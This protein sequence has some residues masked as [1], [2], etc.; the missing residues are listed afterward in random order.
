MQNMWTVLNA[1]GSTP[2]VMETELVQQIDQFTCTFCGSPAATLSLS[3][4]LHPPPVPLQTPLPKIQV[5]FDRQCGCGQC[6]GCNR[7]KEREKNGEPF[8]ERIGHVFGFCGECCPSLQ[9]NVVYQY[10][11]KCPYIRIDSPCCKVNC[12][13]QLYR[14]HFAEFYNTQLQCSCGHA[15]KIQ[16]LGY[17]QYFNWEEHYQKLRIEAQNLRNEA[18]L[19][20]HES[21]Y[22]RGHPLG[23]PCPD[24]DDDEYPDSP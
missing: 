23:D 17:W 7:Q 3:D 5:V 6:C 14:V 4:H 18:Y 2:R 9:K 12:R 21:S 11:C 15:F 19:G 1:K 22:Y 24:F 20:L 10:C 8:D 16:D 13:D